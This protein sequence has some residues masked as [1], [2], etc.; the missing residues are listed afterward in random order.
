M[1]RRLIFGIRAVVR[2]DSR[3]PL[4]RI[5]YSSFVYVRS[6]FAPL[7]LA[8]DSSL[9]FFF[10]LEM[11]PELSSIFFLYPPPLPGDFSHIAFASPDDMHNAL[12]G[13]PVHDPFF[14]P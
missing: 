11:N 12:A 5:D 3:A 1:T 2:C 10:W 4:E 14:L 13:E 9:S 6:I 8:C 7:F